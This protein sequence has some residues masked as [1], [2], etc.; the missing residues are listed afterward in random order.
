MGAVPPS[1]GSQGLEIRPETDAV[2]AIERR[3]VQA[4]DPREI[5]L[6]AEIR[7]EVIRHNEDALDRQ[8]TR[9]QRVESARADLTKSLL[10]VSVGV[11]LVQQGYWIVGFLCLGAGLYS[12]APDYVRQFGPWRRRRERADDEE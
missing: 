5:A 11:Y 4:Q 7:G 1:E 2:K 8:A 6:W 9:R 10:A 12:L 3:L